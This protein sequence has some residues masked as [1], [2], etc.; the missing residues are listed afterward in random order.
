MGLEQVRHEKASRD[1]DATPRP[2]VL[3]KTV[4]IMERGSK[5]VV[6]WLVVPAFPA[7]T[8]VGSDGTE[9]QDT[10]TLTET[11]ERR[12]KRGDKGTTKKG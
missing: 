5:E 7:L 9:R 10:E 12:G 2:W 3:W 6:G 1:N 4:E 8:A 11:R